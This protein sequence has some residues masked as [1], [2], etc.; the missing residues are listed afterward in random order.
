MIPKNEMDPHTTRATVG[1]QPT[2]ASQVEFSEIPKASG[3]RLELQRAMG[4]VWQV[5]CQ[6]HHVLGSCL[7]EGKRAEGRRRRKT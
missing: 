7:L 6:S 4:A 5:K 1:I 2:E 3:R